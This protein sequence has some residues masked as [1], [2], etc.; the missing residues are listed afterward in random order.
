MIDF[1]ITFISHFN[2]LR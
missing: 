2:C 1:I